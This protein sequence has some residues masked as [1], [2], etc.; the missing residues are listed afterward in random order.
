MISAYAE[1]LAARLSFD[2]SLAR[3]VRQEVEDHLK[4]AVAADATGDPLEAQRRAIANFGDPRAIAAQF[5][6]ASLAGQT[7]KVG[8]TVV[9]VIA[10]VFLAMAS[11]VAWY[12]L[13]Q[14]A[15]CEAT[16]S[17]RETVGLIDRAAFCFAVLS[18]FAGWAYVGRSQ[19]PI[20]F[21]P[22]YHWQLR[23]FLL[24]CI[25]AASGLVASVV[26]DGFLTA[27]RLSGWEF[28][29]NFL[30]PYSVDGNRNRLRIAPRDPHSRH[31]TAH[32]VDSGS[33]EL[34]LGLVIDCKRLGVRHSDAERAALAAKE[35]AFR[36]GR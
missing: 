23:R 33:D 13:T 36:C 1:S 17:L 9:L 35:K 20:G 25:L 16:R 12:D 24:L 26:C 27:L 21:D 14:W 5:A 7:R 28:S 19:T 32:R 15:V 2:R 10:G 11:R 6:V 29:V 8:A 30:I 18:G 31:H 4:E 3:R 34:T 22:S